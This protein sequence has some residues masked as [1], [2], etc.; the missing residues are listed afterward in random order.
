MN[1]NIK[2]F[3]CDSQAWAWW[4]CLVEP[5]KWWPHCESAAARSKYGTQPFPESLSGYCRGMVRSPSLPL[6][7]ATN[8]STSLSCM[9][10]KNKNTILFCQCFLWIKPIFTWFLWDPVIDSTNHSVHNQYFPSSLHFV[11]I[12]SLQ[13]TLFIRKILD[14][15]S[16]GKKSFQLF[17][18]LSKTYPKT[19]NL[20]HP[21]PYPKT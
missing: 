14:S 2:S 9:N 20:P 17:L 11:I 7:L 15:H 8:V 21:Y 5:Y 18:S 12:Y 10:Y 13:T 4:K 16:F 3:D 6:N 1:L 19:P